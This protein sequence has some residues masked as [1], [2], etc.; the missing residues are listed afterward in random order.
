MAETLHE[1]TTFAAYFVLNAKTFFCL[2]HFIFSLQ[3]QNFVCHQNQRQHRHHTSTQQSSH[4]EIEISSINISIKHSMRATRMATEVQLARMQLD[5]IK[6]R[7]VKMMPLQPAKVNEQ[8]FCENL[9]LKW[10]SFLFLA[11]FSIHTC[12]R[13]LSSSFFFFVFFLFESL[14]LTRTWKKRKDEW[15]LV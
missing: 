8:N 7:R 4:R 12:P 5:Q 1:L 2:F 11:P 15:K 13:F 10:K 6:F 9:C 14:N 3:M